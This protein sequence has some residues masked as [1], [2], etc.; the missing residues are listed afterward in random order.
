MLRQDPN[1][2][3]ALN[4]LAWLLATRPEAT[5]RNGPEA[6]ELAERA[7]AQHQEEQPELLDTLAAAYAEAGR[8]PEAVRTAE[9]A[10]AAASQRE[11]KALSD[12]IQQRLK[13]YRAGKPYREAKSVGLF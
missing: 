1:E 4:S 5:I 12:G 6:V 10:L 8:F 7:V 13:L 11:N 3:V 9:K 2:Q